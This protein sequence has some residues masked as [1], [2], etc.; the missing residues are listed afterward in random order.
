M[1]TRPPQIRRGVGSYKEAVRVVLQHCDVQSAQ[2]GCNSLQVHLVNSEEL[3]CSGRPILMM[4]MMSDEKE[5]RDN[6]E[7]DIAWMMRLLNCRDTDT[8]CVDDC[9]SNDMYGLMIHFAT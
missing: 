5:K 1:G 2:C 9:R 3:P 4:Q 7:E 8:N 6:C